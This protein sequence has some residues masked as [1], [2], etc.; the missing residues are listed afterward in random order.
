AAAG[1]TAAG[2]ESWAAP[3]TVAGSLGGG[4]TG[5]AT[6]A[7]AVCACRRGP[8]GQKALNTETFALSGESAG[9]AIASSRGAARAGAAPFPRPAAPAAV[10]FTSP[11]FSSIGVGGR[12]AVETSA[13][14]TTALFSSRAKVGN[15]ARKRSNAP[16]SV[17]AGAAGAA[18]DGGGVSAT[19][20]GG[21]GCELVLI[22]GLGG[23][24]MRTGASGDSAAAAGAS[25]GRVGRSAGR[26]AS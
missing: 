3:W 17:G 24:G 9:R 26:A 18:G 16:S 1:S 14:A 20:T 2:L 4:A 5:A 15:F 19:A 12:V 10:L 8:A 7:G 21:S 25:P 13:L 22:F 23:K 6:W 11:M